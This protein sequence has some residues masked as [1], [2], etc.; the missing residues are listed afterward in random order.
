M[1]RS[2]IMHFLSSFHCLKNHLHN[3]KR[4]IYVLSHSFFSSKSCFKHHSMTDGELVTQM[5]VMKALYEI[6]KKKLIWVNCKSKTSWKNYQSIWNNNISIP[7]P[8]FLLRKKYYWISS[9]KYVLNFHQVSQCTI[10]FE[11]I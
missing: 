4:K 3:L 6:Q 8:R 5:D 2:R 1:W 11:K 7:L 9:K 10:S